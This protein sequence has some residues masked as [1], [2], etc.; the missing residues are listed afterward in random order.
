VKIVEAS[1]CLRITT[2]SQ[3]E[4]YSSFASLTQRRRDGDTNISRR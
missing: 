4:L 2:V 3:M 1:K